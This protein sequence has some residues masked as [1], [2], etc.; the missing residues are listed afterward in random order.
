VPR[1]A[2]S[3]GFSRTKQRV[4]GLMEIPRARGLGILNGER[5]LELK[6]SDQLAITWIWGF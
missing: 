1:R 4:R 6:L 3:L 5:W 2:T